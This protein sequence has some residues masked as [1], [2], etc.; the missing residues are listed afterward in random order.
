MYYHVANLSGLAPSTMYYYRV[1]NLAAGG[2]GQWSQ[3]FS[4]R[5]QATRE[6]LKL[7]Q[8]HLLFG[9]MGSSFAFTLCTACTGDLKCD[10][11]T[12]TPFVPVQYHTN[13]TTTT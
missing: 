5:S 8:Y 4:F 3:T 6:T 10:A 2:D 1:G 12:N 7:P 11:S 9:D 13:N